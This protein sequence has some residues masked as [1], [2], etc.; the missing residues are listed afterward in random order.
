MSRSSC[1]QK[2][3]NGRGHGALCAIQHLGVVSEPGGSGRGECVRG[4]IRTRAPHRSPR[5]RHRRARSAHIT[6]R[7]TQ[8]DGLTY[9]VHIIILSL[10]VDRHPVKLW[11]VAPVDIQN[12]KK[13]LFTDGSYT[14]GTRAHTHRELIRE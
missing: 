3:K 5:S 1:S 9:H 11:V 14:K 4:A 6:K 12:E 10:V 13:L 8:L 7:E 2:Q